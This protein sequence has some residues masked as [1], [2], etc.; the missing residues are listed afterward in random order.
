MSRINILTDSERLE[1]DSPPALPVD[2][3]VFYFNI[4]AELANKLKKLRTAT[5]KAGFI[6]QY[7][8]FKAC[9][10]F[11]VSNKFH[12]SDIEYVATILKLNF[13]EINLAQYKKK[14][15]LEHK[16]TILKMLN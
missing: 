7:G 15:P 12:R 14:I 2:A 11:F 5:N 6:L 9:K 13:N 16:V 4:T 1:F 10:R 8:Y 3:K